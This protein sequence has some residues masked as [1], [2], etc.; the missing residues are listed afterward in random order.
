M[1]EFTHGVQHHSALRPLWELTCKELVQVFL[2]QL[3][4]GSERDP[5]SAVD[6][7]PWL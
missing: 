6:H 2:P 7:Q 1:E 5:L 4:Q 3:S